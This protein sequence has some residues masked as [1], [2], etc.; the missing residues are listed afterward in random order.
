MHSFSAE[1]QSEIVQYFKTHEGKKKRTAILKT[2]LAPQWN[3]M[4]TLFA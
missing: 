3:I 2:F 4:G 1:E